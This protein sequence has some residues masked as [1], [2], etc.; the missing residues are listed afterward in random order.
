[1]AI[2]S[3]GFIAGLNDETPWS[4]EENKSFQTFVSSCDAILVGRRTYELMRDQDE[5]SPDAYYVVV[6]GDKKFDSGK[7]Q[8]V[9][10]RSRADIPEVDIIGVIGGGELNG[11]LLRLDLI[12]E[13]ILDIEPVKLGA[14][15]RLFGKYDIPLKLKLI[16]SQPIGQYTIQRHYE[17]IH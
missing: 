9:S 12:D 8:K 2:S 13:I 5:L 6:T 15:I 10:I 16:G 3:D 1:M 11:R 14:G 17:V 4:D 7:A